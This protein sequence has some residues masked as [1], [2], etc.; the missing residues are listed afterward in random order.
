MTASAA[1]GVFFSAMGDIAGG[2]HNNI[3]QSPALGMYCNP[4]FTNT[5]GIDFAELNTNFGGPGWRRILARS[6]SD[7]R[8]FHQQRPNLDRVAHRPGGNAATA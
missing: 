7:G 4:Q 8:L 3:T 6:H 5:T 2:R 1:G